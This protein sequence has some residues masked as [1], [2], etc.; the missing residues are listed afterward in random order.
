MLKHLIWSILVLQYGISVAFTSAFV[1]ITI[2]IHWLVAQKTQTHS[3]KDKVL[4]TLTKTRHFCLQLPN[5]TPASFMKL[6]LRKHNVVALPEDIFLNL[7][8]R[9][10]DFVFMCAQ[11]A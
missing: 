5:L 9:Y 3:S 1:R 10:N 8:Y 4:F 7:L 11:N 2:G 6:V